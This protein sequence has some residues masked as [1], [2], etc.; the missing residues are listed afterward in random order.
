MLSWW[1]HWRAADTNTRT[2]LD[3]RTPTHTQHKEVSPFS[4]TQSLR[5]WS[6]LQCSS[7]VVEKKSSS[8]ALSVWFSFHQVCQASQAIIHQP[9]NSPGTNPMN[10]QL[11]NLQY[12]RWETY[13][14]RKMIKSH[15]QHTQFN[16]DSQEESPPIPSIHGKAIPIISTAIRMVNENSTQSNAWRQKSVL[17]V[18]GR[19]T[20]Y[21]P[22]ISTRERG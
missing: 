15:G 16:A 5:P 10:P 3:S 14:D 2:S 13:T 7:G 18:D 8:I 4:A 20:N 9:K 21:R 17:F 1:A 12:Y 6:S 22:A 19:K 11:S